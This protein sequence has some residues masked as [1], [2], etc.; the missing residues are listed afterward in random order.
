MKKFI[1]VNLCS[2]TDFV[3]LQDGATALVI[4]GRLVTAIAEERLTKRKYASGFSESLNYCLSANHLSINDIDQF[5][6]SICCDIVP[7]LSHVKHILN[8]EEITGIPDEK[9]KIIPSHHLSHAYSTYMLSGFDKSLIFIA[10]NEGNILDKKYD[11]YF[12]NSLERI[13]IY[14]GDGN[15]IELIGR[16]QDDFGKHG[17]C[18]LYSALTKIIGYHSYQDAGKTMALA[19]YGTGEFCGLNLFDAQN[20]SSTL[21]I[22]DNI[23]NSISCIRNLLE[24]QVGR[25]FQ[26]DNPYQPTQD[27]KELAWL[28]Q[29]LLE[30]VSHNIVK[31]FADETGIT[32]LCIAGGIGLNCINNRKLLNDTGI[33]KVF[34]QPAAGDTGQCI[35]NALYGHYTANPEA[36][37]SYQTHTYLGRKYSADECQNAILKYPALEKVETQD[38]YQKVAN[39]LKEGAV[40]GLFNGGSEF[41]PRALGHRSLIASPCSM[42]AKKKLDAIKSREYYRPYAPSILKQ[43]AEDYFELKG[44]DP[45]FMIF[46]CHVKQEK[47]DTIPY[48]VHIDGTSRAQLVDNTPVSSE[49]YQIIEAFYKETELPLILNTSFNPQGSPIVETPEDAITCFLNT[50]VDY[51]SLNGVLYKKSNH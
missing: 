51:L 29:N 45:H 37:R 9:I 42:V 8:E 25:E 38:F 43:Y 46:A 48:V 20:F 27:Q 49:Y 15:K 23:A 50:R 34:I 14:I 41:G 2:T 6:F 16:Y 7:T 17:L 3:P 22:N 4:D 35:G 40:I 32:N 13:S 30:T 36:P 11:D 47:R 39:L 26:F 10:D 19:P 5:V 24:A 33:Q 12:K 44:Q 18:S 28:A 31:K 1:G 21:S